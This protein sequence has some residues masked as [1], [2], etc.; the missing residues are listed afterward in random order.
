MTTPVRVGLLW[1]VEV[2]SG[3]C[4]FPVL[5]EKLKKWPTW[6]VSVVV[7]PN[8]SLDL[9]NSRCLT[10]VLAMALGLKIAMRS[11]GRFSVRNVM[12]TCVRLAVIREFA[13]FVLTMKMAM[14]RQGPSRHSLAQRTPP[15][16]ASSQAARLRALAC[17]C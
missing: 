17:L 4:R 13:L 6:A 8:L 15:T 10:P 14:G 1:L 7:P 5:Y 2:P 9:S 16:L 3:Q 12:S 11:F